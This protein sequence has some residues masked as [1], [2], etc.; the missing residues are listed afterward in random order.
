MKK[1][2]NKLEELKKDVKQDEVIFKLDILIETIN[3]LRGN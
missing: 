2:V 3:I 1:L